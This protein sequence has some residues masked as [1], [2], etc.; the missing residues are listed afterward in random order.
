MWRKFGNSSIT[1]DV[2]ITSIYKD[3]SRKIKIFERFS[4]YKFN[5]FGLALH[6]VLKFYTGV[7]KRLKLKNPKVFG[8]NF[9]VC[10]RYKRK[11][12][13]GSL[14]SIL[15]MVK[16]SHTHFIWL[17]TV[18]NIEPLYIYCFSTG[19]NMNWKLNSV[20]WRELSFK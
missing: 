13:R 7:G 1:G 4:S 5:S 8:A 17:K 19:Q 14:P 16:I 11:A 10:R 18:F 20:V 9:C 6:M 2:I 15:N 12:G 3:L